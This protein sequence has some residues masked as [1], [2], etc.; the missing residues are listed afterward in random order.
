M[1]TP[2]GDL[3]SSNR[4]SD[5]EEARLR[6]EQRR[7]LEEE[8]RLK[9]LHEEHERHIEE[10]EEEW[11]MALAAERAEHREALRREKERVS[12]V[13]EEEVKRRHEAEDALDRSIEEH[14]AEKAEASQKYIQLQEAH[15]ALRT[16][17]EEERAQA[18]TSR[19]TQTRRTHQQQQASPSGSTSVVVAA[20]AAGHQESEADMMAVLQRRDDE[21]TRVATLAAEELANEAAERAREEAL[22]EAQAESNKR[23]VD[24]RYRLGSAEKELHREQRLRQAAEAAA[25]GTSVENHHWRTQAAE[26][27]L[28]AGR[29]AKR[30]QKAQLARMSE[31][32]G[33][34]ARE[35]GTPAQAARHS[36]PAPSSRWANAAQQV[37]SGTPARQGSPAPNT[38]MSTTTASRCNATSPTATAVGATEEESGFIGNDDAEGG[39]DASEAGSD[40]VDHWKPAEELAMAMAQGP[41][42]PSPA[43]SLPASP[44]GPARGVRPPMQAPRTMGT[45]N[46]LGPAS[47]ARINRERMSTGRLTLPP[48]V[49][50]AQDP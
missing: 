19:G 20:T 22:Q 36:S 45:P 50:Y 13:L 48:R 30:R 21:I 15:H 44:M 31:I 27:W 43:F 40:Q 26:A 7:E 42:P 33:T 35:V 16:K 46:T 3:L 28:A 12:E 10:R 9:M 24:L 32:L 18:T 11:A 39:G 8:E 29:E 49:R 4:V 34:A 38:M 1:L 17:K 14:S 6:W 23:E 25:A 2:S 5:L 37:V 41:P 47:T